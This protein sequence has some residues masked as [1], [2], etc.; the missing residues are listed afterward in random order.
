MLSERYCLAAHLPKAET[1]S[2]QFLLDCD[3][4]N[5]GCGGGRIEDS[6]KFL[7]QVGSSSLECV[8]FDEKLKAQECPK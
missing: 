6:V 8:E 1:L 4:E 3:T 2:P 5:Y 7:T